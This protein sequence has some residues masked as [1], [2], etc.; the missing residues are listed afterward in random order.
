M[1]RTQASG[2]TGEKNAVPVE[3]DTLPPEA[4]ALLAVLMD[5]EL[6]SSP[7]D[8]PPRQPDTVGQ[9]VADGTGRTRKSGASGHLT[10]GGDLAPLQISDD[11]RNG[12]H[13]RAWDG[14]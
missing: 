4:A 3:P 14:L 7:H 13:E 6:A 11:A 10:V 9:D 12:Y 2:A 8:P 5:R 1:L